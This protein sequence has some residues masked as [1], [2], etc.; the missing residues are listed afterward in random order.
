MGLIQPTG[1]ITELDIDIN[2][3]IDDHNNFQTFSTAEKA[4]FSGSFGKLFSNIIKK[5]HLQVNTE[6]SYYH[7]LGLSYKFK[8][9]KLLLTY[10]ISKVIYFYF[11][12][13]IQP[14]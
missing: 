10:Y 4:Q 6:L 5:E 12:K 3:A 7:L 1:N 13:I 9:H 8:F 11:K 2:N 14:K